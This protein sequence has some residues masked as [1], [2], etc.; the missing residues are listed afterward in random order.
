MIPGYWTCLNSSG[1]I[2]RIGQEG[3]QLGQILFKPD[4]RFQGKELQ[5][6]EDGGWKAGWEKARRIKGSIKYKKPRKSLALGNKIVLL[7]F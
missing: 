5:V 7:W 1:I 3:R 2:A 4:F 6:H